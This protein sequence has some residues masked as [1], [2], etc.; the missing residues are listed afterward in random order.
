MRKKRA[1]CMTENCPPRASHSPPPSACVCICIC[2]MRVSVQIRLRDDLLWCVVSLLS[3]SSLSPTACF[4][5]SAACN[6]N[7]AGLIINNLLFN[8]LSTS[9]LSPT[10]CITLATPITTSACVCAAERTDGAQLSTSPRSFCECAFCELI[11]SRIKTLIIQRKRRRVRKRG[12]RVSERAK[13]S[14]LAI[15]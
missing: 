12:V 10:A 4:V 5:L 1:A 11:S 6:G 9:S 3:T 8:W 15:E 13:A 2:A 14:D 7:K